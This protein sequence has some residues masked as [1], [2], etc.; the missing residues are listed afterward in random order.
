LEETFAPEGGSLGRRDRREV[1]L[2][3]RLRAALERLNPGQP[4]EAISAAI[5]ELSRNRSAMGLVAA[6]REV[7]RLL[8]DG[9]LVSVP[10]LQRGGQSKVRLRVVDWD[11]PAEN[12]WLAINQLSIQGDLSKCLP[13]LV[14]FV[15]GLPL[16]VFEFKKP[17]VSARAAFT[18]N[19]RHYKSAIPQLFW[20]NAFLI[21]SNGTASR[22]GSLSADWER[23]FEW[24]RIASEDEPRRVSL[25]VLLRG[26]CQP[27][28]LLDYIENFTLFSDSKGGL[29]KIIAQNHQVIGVNNAIAATLEAR[30]RGHGRAGGRVLA[31]PGQRQE[32]FDG[33]L[34]PEDPA[35]D[36][37]RLDLRDRH[38]PH[39][40]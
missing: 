30:R 39:R 5:E 9:V 20:S 21:A 1:V 32:L 11:R 6:N 35:Q 4:P 13:D 16:V 2:V 27:Q 33:L 18:D 37:R 10:D 24:K 3:P 19:L 36:S 29:I 31:D 28:R 26:T 22:V 15:N 8:K 12:D 34:Q 7:Y 38:R 25:E 17:G 40:P 14:G 23:F